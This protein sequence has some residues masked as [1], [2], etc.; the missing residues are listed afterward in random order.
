MIEGSGGWKHLKASWESSIS[1]A[2]SRVRSTC[3]MHWGVPGQIN[4]A[5]VRAAIATTIT[6][7][8][9]TSIAPG[10]FP[11]TATGAKTWL[12]CGAR[13]VA[14]GVDTAHIG[15]AFTNLVQDVRSAARTSMRIQN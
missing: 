5:I 3:P 15:F 9:D 2:S 8:L 1:T 11:P 14:I 4:N 12:D 13:F 6:G 7:A 10:V